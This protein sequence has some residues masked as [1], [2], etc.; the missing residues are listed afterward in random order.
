MKKQKIR[1][2]FFNVLAHILAWT[3]FVIY[4]LPVACVIFASFFTSLAIETY[5]FTADAFTLENY[6]AVFT[7]RNA[8]RPYIVSIVYSIV[9]ALAA[10][11][12]C[13]LV[14]RIA[15]KRQHKLDGIFEYGVLV[16][17]M[18]PTTFIALGVLYT[19]NEPRW[20]V[21]D[22]ILIGTVWAMLISYIVVKL[23]FSF[24]MIRAAFFSL[25]DNL[26]EAAKT[27]GA[28]PVYTMI[29]VILPVI[30][31]TVLSVVALN[32]NALLSEYDLSVFLYTPVL[33]PLGIVIKGWSDGTD[34]NG[35]AM[36]LVYSVVLMVMCTISLWFTRGNG[37][38]VLKRIF[39]RKEA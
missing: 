25:D 27:M 5:N 4:M 36:M 14:A 28:K 38:S 8:L 12:I 31:P 32:F 33:Q 15:L 21:G 6:I 24:R 39:K 13:T 9:A 19:F 3:M 17:W 2:P 37:V 16:P 35:K 20:F 29:R 30:L 11:L 10:A 23:P 22:K 26:E 1:N 7:Q 18:L 34:V